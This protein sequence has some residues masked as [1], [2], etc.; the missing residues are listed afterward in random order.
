M[1]DTYKVTTTNGDGVVISEVTLK[2]CD[3]LT[4]TRYEQV[5][6]NIGLAALAA[7]RADFR[8]KEGTDSDV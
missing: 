1:S 8:A 5:G 7:I 3:G 2:Y 6:S 4:P